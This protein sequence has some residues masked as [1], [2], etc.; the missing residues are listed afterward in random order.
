MKETRANE[1]MKLMKLMKSESCLSVVLCRINE[2]ICDVQKNVHS[3]HGDV[4][5]TGMIN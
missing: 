1:T 5:R 2:D 3:R 4:E